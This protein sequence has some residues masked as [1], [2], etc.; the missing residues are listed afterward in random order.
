M[1]AGS[2]KFSLRPWLAALWVLDGN[3]RGTDA[4]LL[5]Q[6][7]VTSQ[8]KASCIPCWISILSDPPRDGICSQW[9]THIA[10]M[11][12]LCL[13]V[14]WDSFFYPVKRP[15]STTIPASIHPPTHPSSI[16]GTMWRLKLGI[17]STWTCLLEFTVCFSVVWPLLL[18]LTRPPNLSP[19][20]EHEDAAS[21]RPLPTSL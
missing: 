17:R 16:L 5:S 15:V 9:G 18:P 7:P 13:L 19:L 12:I 11:A 6:V 1:S 21:I 2:K 20:E 14:W 3:S 8:C 10:G 4:Y